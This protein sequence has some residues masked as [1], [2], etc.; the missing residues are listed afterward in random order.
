MMNATVKSA[1][2]MEETVSVLQDV[3]SLPLEMVPVTRSA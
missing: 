1:T 3:T 2:P